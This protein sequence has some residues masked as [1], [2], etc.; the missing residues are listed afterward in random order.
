MP[1]N[2]DE[3]SILAKMIHAL[4]QD[5]VTLLTGPTGAI[6][7]LLIYAVGVLIITAYSLMQFHLLSLFFRL[8]NR[9]GAHPERPELN[10][11]EWPSVTVQIP[12]YNE[13]YVAASVIDACASMDYPRDR[14]EIQ[15]LDDSTDGTC[16]IIDQR[17]AYWTAQGLQ[18][19]VLRRRERVGYKAGALAYGTEF[20]KGDILSIFDADFRPPID[21]L[22]RTV[23]YFVNPNVGMVQARWGHINRSYSVLTRAQSLLHDA[24][25]MVEQQTRHLA[26]FFIRFNGSAGLWRKTTIHDAGGWQHD[27]V[28]EDLDLCL[29]AQMRGWTF[30]F[31]NDVVA[32]A[33]LPVTMHDYKVQQY[34][35]VK[36]RIQ[37]VRK[38]LPSLLKAD[39]P[40]RVKAHAVHDLLNVF[41]IP[42]A[43]VIALSS[44]WF[45]M[46]FDRNP[47]MMSWVMV[48]GIS[49]INVA[50]FPMMA[51]LA[52]RN[53]GVTLAG[54]LRE[55][56]SNF[57]PFLI[58][59]IGSSAMMCTAII[60]GFTNSKPVFHRTAKYNIGRPD[61]TWRSKIYAPRRIPGLT[62]VEG[63][64]ALYFVGAIV[65]DIMMIS[66]AFLPFHTSMS[67]G[68]G[69]MFIVSIFKA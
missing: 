3:S 59:M 17:A 50:L 69:I 56:A 9:D 38:L 39:I 27:T 14:F 64:L 22:R 68:L 7:I 36:G 32:P 1:H 47:W 35:W 40:L 28:S 16:D 21:F 25:F 66:F 42:A 2:R 43:F 45:M 51:W 26:G 37:V 57:L 12:M 13:L 62:W 67:V 63:A 24:F 30:L 15:V 61:D 31:R 6:L 29:R 18:V 60:A 23:P 34:R 58:L 10:D 19:A 5:V 65:S 44:V 53:Y 49:Q 4:F 46:A 11:D 41:V 54:T 8:R 48:F 20:A 55:F 33:E 52:L